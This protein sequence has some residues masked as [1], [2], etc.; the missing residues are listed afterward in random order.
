MKNKL[1]I[2]LIIA[3]V[4]VFS[5]ASIFLSF[6]YDNDVFY[7]D[8]KNIII[9]STANNTGARLLNKLATSFIE[10]YL[11]SSNLSDETIKL[12]YEHINCLEL[13]ETVGNS[14]NASN[15]GTIIMVDMCY[16][17]DELEVGDIIIFRTDDELINHRIIY[18]DFDNDVLVTKGD[19]NDHI[20]GLIN[21]DQYYGKIVRRIE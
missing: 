7:Q 13:Y 1:E 5:I 19:N 10:E 2:F 15:A 21:F 4:L 6:S 18:L 16:P 12:F 9:S 14:M 17:V 8:E 20:D 3:S 11:I